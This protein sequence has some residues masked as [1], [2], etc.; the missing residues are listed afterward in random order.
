MVKGGR[1]AAIAGLGLLGACAQAVNDPLAVH[2]IYGGLSPNPVY[3]GEL[4]RVLYSAEATPAK[5]GLLYTSMF[6]SEVAAQYAGQATA[7]EVPSDVRSA[8]GEVLYAI[9]PDAAP[10]WGAKSTGIVSGW[11][12]AG[13]GARRATTE[14]ASAI[15]NAVASD[16]SAALKQH[17]PEAAT[18]ADN[19]LRRA[20]QVATLSQQALAGPAEEPALLQQIHEVARQL[21]RGSDAGADPATCGLEAVRRDLDPL[22]RSTG[23]GG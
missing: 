23:E 20:D 15:R 11:A 10:S 6:E 5:Q 22:A 16:G 18:C 21:L 8:L 2:S 7:A 17:G 13:Y 9:D 14:M 1:V 4:P 3:R 19:T 12:G